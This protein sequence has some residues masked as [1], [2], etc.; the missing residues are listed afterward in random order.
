MRCSITSG[1]SGPICLKRMT[2]S[3][4]MTKVSGTP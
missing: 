2:P 3:L 1:V 4:S